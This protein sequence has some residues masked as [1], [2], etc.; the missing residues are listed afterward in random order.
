LIFFVGAAT[1]SI[2]SAQSSKKKKSKKPAPMQCSGCK[3]QTTAP[4]IAT[5]TAE[6]ADALT[7]LSDLARSLHNATP[8]SYEKLSAFASKHA[9]DV[10]GARAALARKRSRLVE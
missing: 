3:P 4:D 7:Q 1:A 5:S 9:N 8:G 2:S 6:D 10:W